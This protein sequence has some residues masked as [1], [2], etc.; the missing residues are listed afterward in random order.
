L[1]N[2]ADAYYCTDG[3]PITR[4]PLY[5][6]ANKTL[7][8]DP[9]FNATV[10]TTNSLFRGAAILA[11]NIAP[12]KYRLRKWADESAA[13]STNAFDNGQDYYV[14]RYAEVLLTRAEALLESGTYTEQ[15]V[16]DLVNQVR[17]R[18]TMP[19][20][21][22]VEG[23]GLT[24][25][26]LIDIVRQE[27]RVETAFEGLRYYDIKRW[28]ILKERAVDTY[29]SVDKIQATG[30]QNRIFNAARHYVWP[31]PQREI[32]ANSAL[33]QHPEWK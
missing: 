2:L 30:I 26:Q 29:M 13:N 4:S 31:I 24:K 7:N 10:V 16:R 28:G 14:L 5:N 20:V 11:T 25:Q 33:E 9:R 32:D 3:L 1:P 19:K 17:T 12:T 15:Q 8:R 22:T 6:A 21:E 18:A 23:T 27:R